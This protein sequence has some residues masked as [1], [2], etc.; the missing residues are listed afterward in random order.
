MGGNHRA[1]HPGAHVCQPADGRVCLGRPGGCA[2]QAQR[3]GPVVGAF[4][5]QNVP[6][7]LLQRFYAVHRLA[8]PTQL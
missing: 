1:A 5:L 2:D 8:P 7:L 4:R 3:T 6:I